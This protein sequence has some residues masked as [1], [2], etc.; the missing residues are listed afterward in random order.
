MRVVSVNY[1]GVAMDLGNLLMYAAVV[2]AAFACF[3]RINSMSWQTHRP[4]PILLHL[5][6]FFVCIKTGLDSLHHRSTVFDGVVVALILV[7]LL[8]SS[9]T[10]NRHKPP[11]HAVR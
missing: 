4:L 10:W 11:A 5:C 1:F 6:M 7:W 8:W 3:F 9:A 2:I